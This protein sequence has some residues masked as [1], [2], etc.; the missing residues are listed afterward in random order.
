MNITKR[1]GIKRKLKTLYAGYT[2]LPSTLSNCKIWSVNLTEEQELEKS[3]KEV[4]TT[5]VEL[6]TVNTH[7]RV[8]KPRNI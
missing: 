4:L 2:T 7:N 5:A 6:K 8:I 3:K 1:K